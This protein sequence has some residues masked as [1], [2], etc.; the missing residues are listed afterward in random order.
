VH[1]EPKLGRLDFLFEKL[2]GEK[3]FQLL[4]HNNR[5]HHDISRLTEEKLAILDEILE[6]LQ[7]ELSAV[8]RRKA[9]D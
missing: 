7:L 3:F 4:S 2:N 1:A 9:K 8:C 5:F 6:T